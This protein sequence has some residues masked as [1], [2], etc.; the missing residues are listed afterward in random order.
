MA[1]WRAIFHI[2]LSSN[3]FP[4]GIL[5]QGDAPEGC[6]SGIR[7]KRVTCAL[8]AKFA[9]DHFFQLPAIDKLR[10]RQFVRPE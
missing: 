2:A 7:S 5:C 9:T 8:D 6:G 3:S 4:G 10:D 1:G